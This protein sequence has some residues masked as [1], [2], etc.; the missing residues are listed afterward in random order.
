MLRQISRRDFV[1]G[2]SLGALGLML[3]LGC[4]SGFG[5]STTLVPGTGYPPTRTGLRGSHAG[6][7]ET[8][9]ALARTGARFDNP[10]DLDEE[11]DLI[12]VGA[13]ISGLT[14]AYEYRKKFGSDSRIL[15]LDNHDDFGGHAKR[16][17]FHQG[18][19]MRLSWGGTMNL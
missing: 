18:G 11:Y 14:A 19:D 8:A 6:S 15:I 9:H 4:S 7:F 12:V 5:D 2:A 3:P 13:G 1:Q 16:N 10:V 17:E